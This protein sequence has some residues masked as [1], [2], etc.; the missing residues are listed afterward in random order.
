[1]YTAEFY[2][3]PMRNWTRKEMASPVIPCGVQCRCTNMLSLLIIHQN[4]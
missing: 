1:M 3:H 2:Q 4:L